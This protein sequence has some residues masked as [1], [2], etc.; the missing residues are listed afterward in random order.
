MYSKRYIYIYISEI[1]GRF[2]LTLDAVTSTELPSGR[3]AGLF[4]SGLKQTYKERFKKS[5]K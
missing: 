4:G 1:A 3:G 5:Y 2:L